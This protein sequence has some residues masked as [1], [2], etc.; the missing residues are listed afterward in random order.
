MRIE[1]I[2]NQSPLYLKLQEFTGKHGLLFNSREW[3]SNYP[4]G[5]LVQCA[6]L[7]NNDEVIGCFVYYRF[8]KSVFTFA[9][10]PPY[11]PNISLF[12]VNPSESVVGKH[13][14]HK[15]ILTE[16][17]DYFDRLGVSA[18]DINLPEDVVDTQPF[19]WK[20]YSSLNRYSYLLDL[21]QQEET[22][23]NNLSSEKRKSINKALK[24]GLAITQTTDLSLVYPLVLQSLSRNGQ[25]KN[26]AVI[27]KILFSFANPANSFAFIAHHN[28]TPIGA[29]FCVINHTKAVYLFGGFD[30]GNKH[31]GA[32]VSCMWQ[33]I[34]KA[35][36]LNL[37]CFDFEGSMQQGNE[38]L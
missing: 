37:A 20:G 15:D 23:W 29:S 25:D 1:A 12:Y 36:E 8:K 11:T 21:N 7:N 14:F 3:L 4:V 34:L 5:Q 30:A 28:G 33:S 35:K 31:H 9:I 6:I 38:S 26:T 10:S 19:I 27:K 24:D 16:M 22:L 17:A 2:H 13:S 32:G 18:V